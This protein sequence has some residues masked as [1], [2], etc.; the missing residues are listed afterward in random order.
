MKKL[1]FVF[2]CAISLAGQQ[3]LVADLTIGFSTDEGISFVDRHLIP[4]G[5][6][7]SVDVYL[8]DSEAGG[9]LDSDGLFGFGLR[10]VSSGPPLGEF[11]KSTINPIFDLSTDDSTETEIIWDGGI[12]D[13]DIP[14]G[15][16][17]FLGRF[18][19]VSTSAGTSLLEFSDLD[20]GT[21]SDN[22]NWV[23]ASADVLDELIFDTANGGQAMYPLTIVAVPEPSSLSFVA[24]AVLF[25]ATR[26]RKSKTAFGYGEIR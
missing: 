11:Q 26:R 22:A 2:A 18:D 7:V 12:L 15:Q 21:G 1:I 14:N 16:N 8:R 5:E 17:L 13:S 24:S 19:F 23:S 6:S 10:A 25:A 4:I 9:V 20:P 3:R